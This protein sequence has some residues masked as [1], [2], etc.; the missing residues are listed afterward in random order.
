MYHFPSLLN[1]I[2]E[3]DLWFDSGIRE[4]DHDDP[5]KAKISNS[6][7]TAKVIDPKARFWDASQMKVCLDVLFYFTT[8]ILIILGFYARICII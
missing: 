6:D 3:D 7:T 5:D 1:R 2:I 8:I 4:I